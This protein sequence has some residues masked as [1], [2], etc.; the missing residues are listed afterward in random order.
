MGL[1]AFIQQ[2]MLLPMAGTWNSW[3][4]KSIF[5]SLFKPNPFDDFMKR[6]VVPAH[7]RASQDWELTLLHLSLHPTT[8]REQLA[9]GQAVIQTKSNQSC[10]HYCQTL[11]GQMMHGLWWHLIGEM[12][13]G[14]LSQWV[15][16][17]R[18]SRLYAQN[19]DGKFYSWKPRHTWAVVLS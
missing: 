18:A 4:F 8:W 19:Y 7:P 3:I 5:Q 17:G 14:D 10:F 9:K 6:T 16:P 13:Q 2:R 15:Y 1:R 12:L 11:C